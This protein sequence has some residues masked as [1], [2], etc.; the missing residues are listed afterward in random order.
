MSKTDNLSFVLSKNTQ[1]KMSKCEMNKEQLILNYD[2]NI[3]F[4]RKMIEIYFIKMI[5]DHYIIIVQT[6]KYK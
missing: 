6:Y 4:L 2:P 3:Y 1:G 5:K